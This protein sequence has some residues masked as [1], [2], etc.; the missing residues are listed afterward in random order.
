MSD[1]KQTEP[2]MDGATEASFSILLYD[3]ERLASVESVNAPADYLAARKLIE[4]GR[5]PAPEVACDPG[6]PLKAHL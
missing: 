6:V 3:G 2:V 5:S 4:A 1:E